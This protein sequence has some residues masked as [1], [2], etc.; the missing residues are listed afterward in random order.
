MILKELLPYGKLKVIFISTSKIVNLFIL[1]LSKAKPHNSVTAA[2]HME[3]HVWQTILL[4]MLSNQL[5]Q[6]T[7]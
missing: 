1:L 3:F 2:E 6:I 4:K 7:C 5:F